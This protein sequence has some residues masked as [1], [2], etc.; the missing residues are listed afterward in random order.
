[1]E[2]KGFVAQDI[3]FVNTAGP[4]KQQA[5]ALRVSGDKAI[6]LRCKMNGYQDTLFVHR[7]LQFYRECLVMGTVDFIFGDTSV[8]FQKCTIKPK[9]PLPGQSNMITAQGR[10]KGNVKTGISIQNCKIVPSRALKANISSTKTY[11]G[12]PWKQFSRTV[13]MESYLGAFIDPEGWHP[14]DGA[15]FGLNKLYYG[16]FANWGPGADT[17]KRVNWTGYHV[18]KEASEVLDFTVAK[19]IKGGHWLDS[20]IVNYTLGFSNKTHQV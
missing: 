20:K 3:G 15:H 14:W 4:A 17:S 13:V 5:V 9:L 19:M 18:V 7:G 11:L 12:R 16:E 8:V 10:L 6:F 2:G 1:V